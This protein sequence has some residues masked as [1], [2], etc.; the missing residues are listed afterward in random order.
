M[1]GAFLTTSLRLRLTRPSLVRVREVRGSLRS[2]LTKR[3]PTWRYTEVLLSNMW[4][5][6]AQHAGLGC[7]VKDRASHES[8]HSSY[9]KGPRTMRCSQGLAKPF[10]MHLQ[11]AAKSM[12]QNNL[13]QQARATAKRHEASL[14]ES[15][16]ISA[17]LHRNQDSAAC[18][19]HATCSVRWPS[20][21]KPSGAVAESVAPSHRGHLA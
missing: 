9:H 19:M 5:T 17:L 7:F 20:S 14:V 1:Y 6:P 12:F 3:N 11:I 13:S 4:C 16:I 2:K 21:P 15:A 8:E 10:L 18:L